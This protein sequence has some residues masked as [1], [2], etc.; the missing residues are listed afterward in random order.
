MSPFQWFEGVKRGENEGR[1]SLVL[2]CLVEQLL[3]EVY[4]FGMF[5]DVAVNMA[6]PFVFK[7]F[8]DSDKDA[9]FF[10]FS[11]FVVDSGTEHTHG[12]A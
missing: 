4:A 8:I 3:E 11:E 12:G 7:D 1:G 9:C 10:D 5:L 2:H 6:H